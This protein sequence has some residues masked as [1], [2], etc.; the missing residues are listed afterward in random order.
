MWDDA[1][2]TWTEFAAFVIEDDKLEEFEETDYGDEE[3]YEEYD[4]EYDEKDEYVNEME[5]LV[6]DQYQEYGD[7]EPQ[8][9]YEVDYLK[10]IGAYVPNDWGQKNKWKDNYF[11]GGIS[12]PEAEAIALAM[13][14]DVWEGYSSRKEC[15]EWCVETADE[16]G[17]GTCCGNAFF[18]ELDSGISEVY[19]A[20]FDTKKGF[21]E[22]KSEEILP[23]YS[24]LWSSR[25]IMEE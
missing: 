13:P 17:Q 25:P 14:S 19:C 2:Q 21:Y 4:E 1:T 7:K 16:L 20:L 18:Q 9:Y 22:R 5:D 12:D 10:S 15:Y 8:Y 3:Y 24:L 11:C 23:E 6:G